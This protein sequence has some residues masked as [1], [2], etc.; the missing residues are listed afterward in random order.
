MACV[1]SFFP[2]RYG[3]DTMWSSHRARWWGTRTQPKPR[4]G[5]SEEISVFM[6]AG[7]FGIR[8]DASEI[9]KTK[10]SHDK[11]RWTTSGHPNSCMCNFL[12]YPSCIGRNMHLKSADVLILQK[13]PRCGTIRTR[14]AYLISPFSSEEMWFTPAIHLRGRC[15]RSSC[16]FAGRNSSAGTAATTPALTRSEDAEGR[17]VAPSSPAA[18]WSVGR[19]WLNCRVRFESSYQIITTSGSDLKTGN[20]VSDLL[21]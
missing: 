14:H 7:S 15:E 12:C 10:C 4:L 16:G 19:R 20:W 11:S 18:H 1:V 3:R 21:F 13:F 8:L 17:S 5:R 6:S 9:F 2:C